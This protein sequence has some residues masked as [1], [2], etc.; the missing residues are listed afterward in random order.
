MPKMG[1]IEL[2]Y[3]QKYEKRVQMGHRIRYFQ[4]KQ[5]GQ[6]P[7]QDWSRPGKRNT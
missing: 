6:R 4:R 7:I 3:D 5:Q 1:G 2:E